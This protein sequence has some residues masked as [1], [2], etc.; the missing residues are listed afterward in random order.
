MRL[1]R[2]IRV[3]A[4]AIGGGAPL[5]V[6]TMTK[7]DTRDVRSTVAQIVACAEAGADIVRLAVPD[8]A[9]ARALQAIRR[10]SPLPLIADIHFDYRL[11]ILAVEA[12]MD[13]LRIN[14]G[15]IGGADRVAEVVRA[16]RERLVP[17][18]IG[19]NSGSLEEDLRARHGGAGAE[20]LV[21]SALRHIRILEDLD[22]R[23]IKVA[24]KASD[25]RRTVEAYRLLAGRCDYPLHLGVTEAG[26]FV[27]GTVRSAVAMGILL[28]EGIG[29]TLRVSLTDTPMAEVHV[30]QEIL[31]SLGLRA[32][33]PRVT[34]CPTCGRCEVNVL[35]VCMQVEQALER[36]Y[37][38]NPAAA[39]PHVAV[40]GCMV[41]GPGEARDADIAVAGGRGRFALYVRGRVVRTVPEADAAAALLD[42]VRRWAPAP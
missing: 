15:N 21:E 34:S 9:A 14:P 18:R 20:A 33:G 13:G 16:A 24:V 17:I 40:M 7:T 37:R 19:V 11:A 36:H 12:G 8:E 4:V 2:Q 32:P 38:E 25:V 10:E 6:Q 41:N 22:Y 26:T 27:A 30:G 35:S 1:S 23:E 29:D 42:E 5:S 28:S 31:R 39:R 3:G